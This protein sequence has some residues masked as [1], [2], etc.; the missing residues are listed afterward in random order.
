LCKTDGQK[1]GNSDL[2][3][4]ITA[5]FIA[6]SRYVNVFLRNV[7]DR[8]TEPEFASPALSQEFLHIFDASDSLTL[9]GYGSA[10]ATAREHALPKLNYWN[11]YKNL[12]GAEQFEAFKQQLINEINALHVEG[13]PKLE[14]LNALVGRYINLE[15]RLPNGK[16]EKFLDDGAT[17]LGNQLECEFGGNR[18]FGIAANMD[19]ILVATYEENG[20]NPQLVVYKKR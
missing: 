17:Y 18:C 8:K 16:C 12:D 11:Q 3:V 5:V 2:L 14:T 6:I 13:M 20:A 10:H 9:H 4:K 7:Y 1:F 19:F 15:Y